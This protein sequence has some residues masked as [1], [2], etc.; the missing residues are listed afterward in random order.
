MNAASALELLSGRGKTEELLALLGLPLKQNIRADQ[1]SGTA[2]GLFRSVTSVLKDLIFSAIEKRT[3]EEFAVAR[4]KAFPR[5]FETIRALSGLARVMVPPE[6]LNRFGFEAVCELE[7]EFRNEGLARFGAEVR[8]QGLFTAWTLRK[9]D[10]LC[11]RIEAAPEVPSGLHDGD[12]K[13]AVEFTVT[14]AWTRFHLDCLI[15]SI[16]ADMTLYPEVLE[17][18]KDGLRSVVNAYAAVKQGVD[19]RIPRAIEPEGEIYAWDEE[20]DELLASS[21]QDLELEEI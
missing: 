4:S 16:Y 10:D 18:I 17:E 7:A 13:L 1:L 2:E 14:L 3:A 8:D 12:K 19:L 9:I 15:A 6:V 11:Q 20:D 5:Y 21:M